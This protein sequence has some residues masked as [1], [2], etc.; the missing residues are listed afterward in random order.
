MAGL[1][2]GDI[3]EYNGETRYT[4]LQSPEANMQT[5]TYHTIT[6]ISGGVVCL[7][8]EECNPTEVT[9]AWHNQTMR[10]AAGDVKTIG[11]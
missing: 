8:C 1:K 2:F 11:T 4:N 9:L 6:N 5:G 7:G 3:V 10:H